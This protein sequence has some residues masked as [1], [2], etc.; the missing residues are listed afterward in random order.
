MWLKTSLCLLICILGIRPAS[1][2]TNST[3]SLL[4]LAVQNNDYNRA[5]ELLLAGANP[6]TLIDNGLKPSVLMYASAFADG[7]VMDLLF[8]AGAE[9]NSLD[10][11][12]DPALNWAAY[13]GHAAHMKKLIAAGADLSIHSKHG[14]ALDVAYRLW[15]ADSVIQVFKGTTLDS[16]TPRPLEQLIRAVR[17]RQSHW[18]KKELPKSI[19]INRLDGLGQGPLHHA[20]RIN[21][22]EIVALLLANGAQPNLLNR[23]GQSPLAIAARYGYLPLVTQL[24]EAGANPNLA[25]ESYGLTPLIGAV[26]GGHLDVIK[27]LIEAGADLDHRDVINQSTALHWAIFYENTKAA[28]LLLDKGASYT[29]A[30]FDGSETAYTLALGYGNEE[31]KSYIEQ[32]RSTNNQLI[33]SWK[34]SQIDYIYSDTTYT[35]QGQEGSLLIG[36]NRYSIVYT[37]TAKARKAFSALSAPSD[38]ETITAFRNIVFNSGPYSLMDEHVF[39]AVPDIAKVPGFEGGRQYYAFTITQDTLSLKLYDET[40]P[41]G[42]KPEW[43]GQLEVLLTFKKEK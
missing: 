34:L 33:G 10:A 19:Y 21:A 25:G 6:N 12:G 22:P 20:V 30:C 40:Y 7:K 2:Q 15:H 43:H 18:L 5:K 28:R 14:N 35:F 37:P 24:L 39:L 8:D 13:Y 29:I 42:Q 26:V 1:A 17:S 11:N 4:S 9:L 3:D 36:R 27:A 32:I 31:L 23:V 38:K 16:G 41:N